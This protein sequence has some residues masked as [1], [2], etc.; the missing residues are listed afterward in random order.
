MRKYELQIGPEKKLWDEFVSTS[1]QGNLF[2]QTKFL[3]AFQKDYELL[4]VVKGEEILL[5]AVIVKDEDGQPILQPFIYQGVLL[6]S[7][8]ATLAGYKRVKKALELVEILLAEIEKRYQ[9]IC[10]SLHP[11]FKD[12]RSFQWYNYHEPEKSQFQINLNYT[13]ILSLKNIQNFDQIL[14]NARTVRR[15]E[16][17]KC[18]KE[19]FTIEESEDIS[20]L[21][22]LHEKTFKRQGI[23]R[24]TGE[25]FMATT[26]AKESLFRGFGRLLVC[27]DRSG[28]TAS[29]SLF[30][31]DDKTAYYLI[32]ANDPKFRKYGTGINVIFEQIRRCLEQGLS[33][34]DF[35]GI[36]SP[37]R[38]DFKTS[39]GAVPVPYFTV[40]LEKNYKLYN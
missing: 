21:D 31:F 16:Y 30:L 3:D 17:R 8:I 29:A 18:I 2:C 5:G 12:L 26:L 24:S 10:F 36:N 11:S 25:E 20:I 27:R 9:Q 15:Q 14:M 28:A 19:G 37:M 4:T 35:V 7:S 13:G 32:G 23:K 40:S 34:V 22:Q 6:G 33:Q 1:P 38:G 39:F